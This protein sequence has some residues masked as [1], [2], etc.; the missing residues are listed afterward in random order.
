MKYTILFVAMVFCCTLAHA[1]ETEDSLYNLLE[2]S[3]QSYPIEDEQNTDAVQLEDVEGVNEH[4]LIEPDAL[5]GTRDYKAEKISVR[6]FDEKKWKAIVGST[7]YEEK[8]EEE[9]KTKEQFRTESTPWNSELL[10]VISFVLIIAIVL[11]LL[12]YLLKNTTFEEKLRNKSFEIHDSVAHVENIEDLDIQ[13]LL[14]KTLAEGNLRLAI[15]LYYLGLLKKLNDVG[16]IAWKR[17]KTN[18]DYLSEL[19]SKEY[20]FEE[21]KKLTLAYEQVWYGEHT[22]THES[23]QKLSHNFETIHQKL[24]TFKPL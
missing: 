6:K 3:P 8:P 9:P 20:Y 1:Q 7:D 11:F 17:D 21:V 10:R 5:E 15:R 23:F 22:I 19:F 2:E 16:L 18:R 14:Q 13:T 12:Y 24:N 4:T